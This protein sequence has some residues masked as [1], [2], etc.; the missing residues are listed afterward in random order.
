[1]IKIC[2][3][4]FLSL[5]LSASSL[6][7]QTKTFAGADYSQ[8]IVFVMENNQ[9]VWKHKAPDSN[10]LWILPNGNILFTT[11]HGV[12]E[13]TR[14][15]DTIFHYESKSPVFACQR[16]K[17]GNTFVG[18]CVTG[19]MLEIS[20]KGKIVKET[21]ILPKGVKDG[22]FAFMRNAR[23][24]DNGHFL[25]AHYGD[26]CVKEYDA[27]GKVVWKLDVPGGPHSLT[28]LPNGHTLIAVAD[29]DQNPR[30]IEVTPE[31]KTI[32]EISNADIPGKPLKFLSPFFQTNQML[33]ILQCDFRL[34]KH[35]A[36]HDTFFTTNGGCA[37]YI[38]H[39]LLMIG[40]RFASFKLG[41]SLLRI[42]PV[43]D[44]DFIRIDM[45]SSLPVIIQRDNLYSS[46]DGIEI[47]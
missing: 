29:K 9:V 6:F 7:A 21:C 47:D 4:A 26:Q 22:G 43:A 2:S 13:M 42:R 14:Q 31:G 15:N 40:Q 39:L 37:G 3:V 28:R 46:F 19:R 41:S 32:W 36:R 16:L 33:D 27:N 12:L 25:V 44:Q 5:L 1:M 18:E 8:G 38:N 17:N 30:L 24:L 20:P 34:H 45:G 11:G 23:R 10:D 35:V